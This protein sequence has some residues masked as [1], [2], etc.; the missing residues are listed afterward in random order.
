MAKI[1]SELDSLG[2]LRFVGEVGV[3]VSLPLVAGALV[4]RWL[5]VQWGTAPKATLVGLVVGMVVSVGNLAR[6][7]KTMLVK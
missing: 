5:D 2:Y 1:K 4:G 6:L 3:V 7:V